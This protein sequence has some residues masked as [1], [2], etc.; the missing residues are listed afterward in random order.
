MT[1]ESGGS[2]SSPGHHDGAPVTRRG[3]LR[4]GGVAAGLALAGCLGGGDG[5]DG[6]GA[7]GDG[8]GGGGD[9]T[10]G[11]VDGGDGAE[12]LGQPT[13]GSPD[14]PV[15]VAVY[16]DFSCPH[17]RTFNQAVFPRVRDELV[18]TGRA[19]LVHYDFPIPVDETWSWRA[20]SAARAVQAQAGDEAFFAFAKALYAN[21]GD[22][23]LALVERL[24]DEVGADGAAVRRAAKEE[25]YR[26]VVRAN[27]QAGI[28]DGVRGTPTVVVAGEQVSPSY[29][30][31]AAAVEAAS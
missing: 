15:A 13:L 31:I 9:G 20:A 10:V 21:Q 22:Y 1:S 3:L 8:A 14:A 24:A 23:S 30:D 11:T 6:D 28:D 25:T 12:N 7:G 29:A 27:R 19:R 4:A 26:A 16:E 2:D 18:D 17:C 5:G